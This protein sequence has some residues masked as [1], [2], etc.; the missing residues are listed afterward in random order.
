MSPAEIE[1]IAKVM[2]RHGL[3][4]I[5]VGPEP[6]RLV[7]VRSEL[8]HGVSDTEPVLASSV[9]EQQTQLCVVCG[10]RPPE[11]IFAQYGRCR[12]CGVN[13]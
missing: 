7:M 4:R 13:G 5:E 12:S 10:K 9:D 1:E 8:E 2:A 3:E 6:E 11:G